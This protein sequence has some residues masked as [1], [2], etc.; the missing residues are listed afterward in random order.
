VVTAISVA[1]LEEAA[2]GGWRAPEEA[3]LGRWRLRA[4]GGV[5]GRA[6]SALALSD[7]GMPLDAAVAEVCRW[8]R[9]RGLPPMVAVPYPLDRAKDSVVDRFLAG[10]GWAVRRGA[11]TVMTGGPQA[12]A[13][14]VRALAPPGGRPTV[15]L[16]G[17]P[18]DEWLAL[19]HPHGQPLPEAGRQLLRSAPWQA[20]G[21]VREAGRTIAIGRVAMADGWAGLTAIEVHPGHRR[22]GLGGTVTGALAAAA[23]ARGAAG[24]YLQVEND[25]TP[26]RALY[27]GLGFADHHGY[28]YRLA[29]ASG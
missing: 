18:G 9:A 6:N 3:A 25:N 28:H 20:F 8:Y 5:T 13:Q 11:A 17:T 19:Y 15:V 10:E 12:V 26:A 2:A 4:A 1:G 23:A 29:P 22:R 27:R 21:A 7:P 24:L 14:R 16:A